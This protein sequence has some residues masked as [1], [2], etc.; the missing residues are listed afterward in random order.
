M[1]VD[2]DIHVSARKGELTVEKL[3]RLLDENRVDKAVVWP[4]VSYTRQVTEDNRAIYEGTKRY[5]GRIV[6]FGGLNPRLGKEKTL[7]ELRRCVE[8]YGMK[9]FKLNGARDL[10]IIDE[11][12]MT[13]PIIEKI[14]QH[15]LV[16]A[17]HSGINDPVRT[18]PWRIGNIARDFPSAKILMIHMGKTLYNSAIEIAQQFSNITLVDSEVHDVSA[19]R[20]VIAELGAK[21]LCYGSDEPFTSMKMALAI[22]TAILENMSTREKDLIMGLNV[23]EI[24]S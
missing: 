3:I 11:K 18:H 7:T 24:L 9:G 12:E 17:L 23:L 22:H 20:K 16:L 5:P 15:R 6:P 2:A 1:I 4:M 8:K 19:V 21:R 14:V 13:Y 10:Y